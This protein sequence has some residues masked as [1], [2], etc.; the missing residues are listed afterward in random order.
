MINRKVL[1]L[2]IIAIL[3]LL[4]SRCSDNALVSSD[5]CSVQELKWM[6]VTE[7]YDSKTVIDLATKLSV[8]AKADADKIKLLKEAGAD[9]SLS[10]NL[11]RII[12][13]SSVKNA[14]VSKEFFQRAFQYRQ[15]V[16]S[17]ERQIKDGILT[18]PA[19]LEK[20]QLKLIDFSDQFNSIQQA[21]EAKDR[22]TPQQSGVSFG[23]DYKPFDLSISSSSKHVIQWKYN[24]SKYFDVFP[25]NGILSANGS[26]IIR[27]TPLRDKFDKSLIEEEVW[28]EY[29]KEDSK[30]KKFSVSLKAINPER[31]SYFIHSI[32]DQLHI[33]VN[34]KE[35]AVI[36]STSANWSEV[37]AKFFD[38]GNNEIDFR[39]HN[40]ASRRG[41]FG[42]REG[43]NYNVSF[44][45]GSKDYNY[46][47]SSNGEPPT[48]QWGTTFSVKKFN[49]F[50]DSSTGIVTV[51]EK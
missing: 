28:F 12:N 49:L 31:I 36:N 40:V 8:A 39:V 44:K 5:D 11:S 37:P 35:Y 50:L 16:C 30:E 17:I 24:E 15:A 29:G 14:E 22:I 42:C 41:T 43:W 21:E 26:A 27:I 9:V 34:S 33:F 46:S 3:P 18:S 20:A 45:I 19:A 10:S 23:S 25:E 51:S 32:D 13:A 1:F 6:K 38:T 4:G 48:Q 47:G 7:G 2:L